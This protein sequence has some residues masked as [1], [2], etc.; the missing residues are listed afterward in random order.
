MSYCYKHQIWRQYHFTSG[1]S[2]GGISSLSRHYILMYLSKVHVM[3]FPIG[4]YPGA[5]IKLLDHLKSCSEYLIC[6]MCAPILP[7]SLQSPVCKT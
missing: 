1:T 2:G 6:L 3:S 5:H 7:Y 4:L